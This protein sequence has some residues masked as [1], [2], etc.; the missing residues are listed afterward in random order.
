VLDAVLFAFVGVAFLLHWVLA[1]PGFE[2]SDTQ[3]DWRH[4]LGFSAA[5]LSLAVALPVFAQ[6]AGRGDVV[7]VS[8]GAAAGAALSSARISSRTAFTWAG[9]STS[10]FWAPELSHS[11]WWRW[12]RRSPRLWREADGSP[13]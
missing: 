8:L 12:R 7:R 6:A 1:D 4:V 2:A 10:S 11:A 3:D 13:R 5:L 9:R